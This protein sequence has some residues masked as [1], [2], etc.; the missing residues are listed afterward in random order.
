MLS[1][2]WPRNCALY[3]VYWC[4]ENFR[5]SLT[6]PTATFPEIVNGRLLQSIVIKCAQ[7]TKFEDRSF[8]RSWDNRGYG[9]KKWTAPRYSHAPFSPKFLMAFCSDGPCKC[10]GQIW[11]PYSFTRSWDNRGYFKTF[12]S[13]WLRPRSLFFKIFNGL[14]FGWTLNIPAKFEVRSF[15]HSWD[16]SGYLKLCTV[17]GYAV[18][19]HA[20][21]L[22]LV[23]IES[24]YAT[25]Y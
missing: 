16:N 10:T 6:T 23:P 21:S 1:Q 7:R 14:L 15:T 12:G 24:A 22:F 3:I 9:T 18:Q 19:G 13:P 11:S 2:R 4:P 25:S 20:R 5:V 17:P 8:T